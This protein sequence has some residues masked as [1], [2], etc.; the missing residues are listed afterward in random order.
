MYQ[1]PAAIKTL[2]SKH[3]G[4]RILSQAHSF[5]AEAVHLPVTALGCNRRMFLQRTTKAL[6][7][8]APGQRALSLRAR[9]MLLLAEGMPRRELE[10]MYH[11]QG[12]A[13]LQQLMADGYLRPARDVPVGGEHTASLAAMR[14][15]LF[16]LCERMFA[17]RQHATAEQLRHLLREA[18]DADS[19]LHAQEQLLYAV[20]QHAGVDRAQAL[21]RQLADWLPERSLDNA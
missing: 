7:E 15:H 1:A 6:Q 16:D 9:S 5:P 8:L 17:N 21:R 19:M 14:M 13:L 2:V 3:N 20:Q 12:K 18:R 11:G 4:N 10:R